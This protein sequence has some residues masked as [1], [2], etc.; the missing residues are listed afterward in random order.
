MLKFYS[1]GFYDNNVTKQALQWSG[2]H[3]ATEKDS[4]QGILGNEI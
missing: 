3:K 1:S 2:H 4:G